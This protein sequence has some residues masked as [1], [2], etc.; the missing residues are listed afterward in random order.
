MEI[1]W[2]KLS[3][4]KLIS[5]HKYYTKKASSKIA[6][7][8]VSEI[9]DSTTLLKEFPEHGQ[10]EHKLEKRAQNFRYL[11]YKNYKIIY[12]IDVKNSFVKISNVFDTRQNPIKLGE[13]IG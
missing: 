8:L 6:K 9:I 4:K 13:T 11:V 5:I 10:Q 1:I 3:Q 12:F 7:K 2:S